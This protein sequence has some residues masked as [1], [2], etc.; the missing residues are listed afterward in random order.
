VFTPT[1]LVIGSRM[2]AVGF[3]AMIVS[4]TP[5]LGSSTLYPGDYLGYGT[6]YSSI[7]ESSIT[8]PL[9]LYGAPTIYG[10]EMLRFGSGMDFGSYSSGA[11]GVDI[12]SGKL[13]VQLTPTP[14]SI[15]DCVTIGEVGSYAIAGA[16]GTS[17]TQVNIANGAITLNITGIDGVSVDGPSVVTQ[18][19]YK[20]ITGSAVLP[21]ENILPN[22]PGVS[23]LTLPITTH[24]TGTWYGG[25]YIYMTPLL[26][27][28]QWEGHNITEATLVFDNMLIS[29]SEAGTV[30]FV[31]MEQLWI[32]PEPCTLVVVGIAALGI[33]GYAWRRKRRELMARDAGA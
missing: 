15:M 22:G 2:F 19:V 16:G 5:A 4:V 9:P 18:M 32:T 27:G 29:Q 10:T 26:V 20:N 14:G 21:V 1:K 23:D 31:N 12:T 3:C 6:K 25:A 24:G 30:A 17:A 28:T 11:G 13:Y 8:D 7:R 33:G